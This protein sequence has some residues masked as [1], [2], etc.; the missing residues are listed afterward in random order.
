MDV[1]AYR[2]TSFGVLEPLLGARSNAP[3]KPSK[4]AATWRGSGSAE[5]FRKIC[6]AAIHGIV[7]DSSHIGC[8]ISS[9]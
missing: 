3:A 9:T 2:P 7:A 4:R 5:K 1:Q 6:N 8:H